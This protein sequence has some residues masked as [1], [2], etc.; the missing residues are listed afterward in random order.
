MSEKISSDCLGLQAG[1]GVEVGSCYTVQVVADD[2]FVELAP[3][4]AMPES[5]QAIAT[6]SLH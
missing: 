2:L 1:F 4:P 6:R 5:A 3:S